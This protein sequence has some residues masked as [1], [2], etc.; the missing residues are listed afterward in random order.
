M[1]LIGI[2][3]GISPPEKIKIDL[4]NAYETGET[5][6]KKFI[7]ERLVDQ[8]TEFYDPI[9]K[10]KLA[11][12][13]SLKKTVKVKTTSREVQFSFQSDIFGKISLVQQS[14]DIDLKEVLRYPLGP[15]PWSLATSTGQMV[16]TSKSA[17]MHA[18]E[19]G[20]THVDQVDAPFASVIYGMALVRKLK[21]IG[22]TFNECADNLLKLAVTNSSKAARVDIVFDVYRDDSIKLAE[23]GHRSVGTIQFKQIIGAAPIKQW[24]S[25]LSD[26]KNKEELIRFLVRRWKTKTSVIGNKKLYIAF[27]EEC[28]RIDGGRAE[29]VPQLQSNQEEADTRMLLHAK[30]LSETYARVVIHT[31]DTDVLLIAISVSSDIP[32]SLFILTGTKT[33]VRIISIDKV[34][35]SLQIVYNMG[36]I[37]VAAKSL[38]ALHAFSGCDTVSAFS[39]KGKVKPLKLLMKNNNYIDTFAQIG[40]VPTLSDVHLKELEKFVCDLYGRKDGDTNTVRYKIYSSRQGKLEAKSIPPCHDSLKFHAYRATY[41]AFIWRNCLVAKP[42][43]PSPVGFGWELDEEQNLSIKWNSLKPAPDEILELMYCS[44]SR[45][46]G[47][48]CPCVQNGLPCTDACV[49]QDCENFVD[50]ESNDGSDDEDDLQDLED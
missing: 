26:G 9:K 13:N 21:C 29:S 6:M 30:H 35:R 15:V 5:A 32:A 36:D 14:R 16:K 24:G 17:L 3:T 43:V 27:D 1:D 48:F 50:L 44:C 31:P 49:K 45:R 7:Q 2:S 46:C 28:I 19:K 12:F 41:Q 47:E 23:R 10:L 8:S 11:T 39:G 38:V 37:N 33:N 18:L 4:L 20:M 22:M 34:K 25:F 40:T 42:D